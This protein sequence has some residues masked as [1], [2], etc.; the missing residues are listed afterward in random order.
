LTKQERIKYILHK[1]NIS[2]L[3]T[4]HRQSKHNYLLL[5]NATCFWLN[6]T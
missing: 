2:V 4:T 3:I 5:E 6:N 1:E